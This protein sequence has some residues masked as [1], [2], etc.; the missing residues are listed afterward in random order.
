MQFTSFT[1]GFFQLVYEVRF[2]YTF[3]SSIEF[4]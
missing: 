1:T 4:M 3:P 2:A